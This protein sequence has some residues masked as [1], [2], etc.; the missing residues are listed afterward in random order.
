MRECGE[1]YDEFV[2]E[3]LHNCTP[4]CKGRVDGFMAESD[5]DYMLGTFFLGR[6][7]CGLGGLD[8]WRGDA[9]GVGSL[10]VGQGLD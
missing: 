5:S 6:T 7:G 3:A 2:D 1:L 10:G 9:G 8:D 4:D